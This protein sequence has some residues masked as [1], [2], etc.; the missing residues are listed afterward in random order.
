MK[1]LFLITILLLTTPL[2]VQGFEYGECN[3]VVIEENMKGWE[4]FP[5]YDIFVKGPNVIKGTFKKF[6]GEHPNGM[7]IKRNGMI[8]EVPI[9]IIRNTVPFG[10]RTEKVDTLEVIRLSTN[11]DEIKACYK[12]FNQSY[13]EGRQLF[14][15]PS[16]FSVGMNAWFLT[17]YNLF[18]GNFKLSEEDDWVC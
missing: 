11:S 5:Q 10:S 12:K 7:K 18:L 16:G 3:V 17:E 1:N 2:V 8:V 13:Q 15:Q 14:L 6:S 4:G 9:C